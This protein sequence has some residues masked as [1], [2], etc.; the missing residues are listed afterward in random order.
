MAQGRAISNVACT[1]LC[2]FW[3]V[4]GREL[5]VFG[6]SFNRRLWKQDGSQHK[7]NG[8]A[9]RFAS[10]PHISSTRGTTQETT[11]P[12]ETGWLGSRNVMGSS[13][14]LSD[15]RRWNHWVLAWAF[16]RQRYAKDTES[17]MPTQRFGERQGPMFPPAGCHEV[18]V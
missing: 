5:P 4:F 15:A 7:R 18:H 1:L 13:T 17:A 11:L 9:K 6:G 3:H 8:I 2:H 10:S 12:D 14:S 16:S